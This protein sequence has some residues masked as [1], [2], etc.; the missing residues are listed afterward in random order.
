MQNLKV[1]DSAVISVAEGRTMRVGKV[2]DGTSVT[3]SGGGA[4]AFTDGAPVTSQAQLA[5]DPSVDF[6][7]SDTNKMVLTSSGAVTMWF[8]RNHR[9][10]AYIGSGNNPSLKTTDTT[11]TG[12]PVVNMGSFRSNIHFTFAKSLNSVRSAYVVMGTASQGGGGAV[13]G[14]ST[15]TDAEN[16][17][18]HDFPFGTD[19]NGFPNGP[20]CR[21]LDIKPWTPLF[22]PGAQRYIDGIAT[23]QAALWRDDG[24]TYDL[25]EVHLPVGAHISGICNW[26][27]E[28]NYSG[29]GRIAEMVVYERELSER[30]KVATRNYLMKKWLGTAD[31]DLQPLPAEEPVSRTLAGVSGEGTVVADSLALSKLVADVAATGVPAVTGSIALGDELEVEVANASALGGEDVFVPC[32]ACASATGIKGCVV[33]FTGDI[34]WM[35]SAKKGEL[36][37]QDGKLGVLFRSP[38]G[39]MMILR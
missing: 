15:Y 29:G 35:S 37:F 38:R 16:A 14:S 3:L 21:N 36:A 19:S 4:V 12:L 8:D 25:Y 39:L 2:A 32:V 6:D 24:A 27:D 10:M 33:T 7:A 11:P 1:S 28:Y 30:E 22:L 20:F 31:E 13:F 17:N 34:S 23:N 5:A 9:N 18:Y 26:N